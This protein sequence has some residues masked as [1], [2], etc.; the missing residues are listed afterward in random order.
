MLSRAAPLLRSRPL[1]SSL[2]SPP[3]LLGFPRPLSSSST[4]PR[5]LGRAAQSAA[6]SARTT[7][8]L[9]TPVS[10]KGLALASVLSAAAAGFYK[11]KQE[12]KTKKTLSKVVTTGKPSLGGDW[13]L[14]DSKTGGFVTNKTY[15]GGYTV[16]Y[17][18]FAHCPDICPSELR[19]LSAVI[20]GMKGE[21][22]LRGLFVTV[23]PAR[24]SMDNLR[25][26]AKDFHPGIE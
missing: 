9:K 19:K 14:L 20:D 17:F 24:D 8:A 18:G 2:R 21:V 25:I 11:L 10:W 13:C 4:D 3:S 26:Y 5:P 6:Q 23:D 12:E 7:N 22:D 15:E 1:A 16:V